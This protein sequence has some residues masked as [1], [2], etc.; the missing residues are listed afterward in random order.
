MRCPYC[1]NNRTKVLDSRE[2]DDGNSI[3]RRRQCKVCL[4]RFTTYEIVEKNEIRVVKKHGV[5]ESFKIEKIRR[6]I[7]LACEKLN[8]S[9]AKIDETV[10]RIETRIRTGYPREITTTV[11]GNI[12][13]E[14]LKQLH[15]VAYV[16]FAAVYR[17]F[18]DIDSFLL[19]LES[20]RKG[21]ID[22]KTEKS[23]SVGDET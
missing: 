11:I 14:E 5:R 12:V 18:R 4:Q 17:E 22:T 21:E 6:G 13:M 2:S 9:A 3:R 1:K 23:V 16:R 15:Q 7:V 10:D 8:I 20:L 19:E